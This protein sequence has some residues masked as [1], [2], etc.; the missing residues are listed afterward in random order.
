MFIQDIM[1]IIL[2]TDELKSCWMYVVALSKLPRLRGG[3]TIRDQ[4]DMLAATLSVMDVVL[5]RG[6]GT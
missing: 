1:P 3:T 5:V 2:D 4:N 6:M